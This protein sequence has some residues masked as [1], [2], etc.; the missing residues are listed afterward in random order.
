MHF[1]PEQQRGTF[2][3]SGRMLSIP[4]ATLVRHLEKLPL[5]KG[6][7]SSPR[8]LYKQEVKDSLQGKANIL[9]IMY[10]NSMPVLLHPTHVSMEAE[11]G[12]GSLRL[13]IIAISL[14]APESEQTNGSLKTKQN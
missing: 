4:A 9:E 14:P 13:Q 8:V 5:P 12:A 11:E 1:T 10:F 6:I 3:R 7:S 2:T